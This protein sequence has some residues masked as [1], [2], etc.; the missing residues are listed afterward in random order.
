MKEECTKTGIIW[1]S[2]GGVAICIASLFLG[3]SIYK[4]TIKEESTVCRPKVIK[5]NPETPSD[6]EDCSPGSI[7]LHPQKFVIGGKESIIIRCVCKDDEPTN[8]VER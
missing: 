1:S 3:L 6:Y 7:A 8:F 2:F 5:Y 4:A